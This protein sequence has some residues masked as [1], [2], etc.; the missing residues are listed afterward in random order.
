MA[1]W[2]N[3]LFRSASR[4]PVLTGFIIILSGFFIFAAVFIGTRVFVD[5][6]HVVVTEFDVEGA[7][8]DGTVAVTINRVSYHP[9]TRVRGIFSRRSSVTA[10]PEYVQ[11]DGTI[12]LSVDSGMAL[13]MAGPALVSLNLKDSVEREIRTRGNSCL[14][15]GW[16]TM[17]VRLTARPSDFTIRIP[18]KDDP[19]A[20]RI[21]DAVRNG[22][23]PTV[24]LSGI[25][26]ASGSGECE[27]FDSIT[28]AAPHQITVGPFG[29]GP[30][31]T[32]YFYPYGEPR[33]QEPG[34]LDRQLWTEWARGWVPGE[35]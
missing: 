26:P 35:F 32:K 2:F 6:D 28:A 5:P 33:F 23:T 12:A 13:I 21:L 11:I 14:L 34:D 30:G 16:P 20:A 1:D 25:F 31:V 27:S 18:V 17:A 29:A 15:S 10:R 22:E 8:D 4:Y 19:V 7:Y 24:T 9:A 3:S